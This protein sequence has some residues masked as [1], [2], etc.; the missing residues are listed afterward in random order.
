MKKKNK[1]R[2]TILHKLYLHSPTTPTQ[3][4]KET[5][6]R[7]IILPIFPPILCS[8]NKFTEKMQRE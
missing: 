2:Y 5:K 8:E 7:R 4:K 3:N 6:E 1:L